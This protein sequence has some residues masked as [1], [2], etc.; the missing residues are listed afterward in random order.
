[1][2]LPKLFR[3]FEQIDSGSTRKVGG[4]G[5]G[6]VISKG[7]IEQHGGRIGVDSTPGEGS[8]F[9]FT[10]PIAGAQENAASAAA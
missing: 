7:I 9:W 6:L 4:T 2:D 5:L 10:L 3:K 8:T 1:K